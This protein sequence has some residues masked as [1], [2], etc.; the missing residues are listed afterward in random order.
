MARWSLRNPHYLNVLD[1]EGKGCEW[2]HEET[3][4]ETGRRNRKIYTV[5]Q[6][7]DPNNPQDQNYREL[8]RIIVCHQGKG[9][10]RDITFLG[11][12]TP[13]M[14]PFDEEAEKISESLRPKWEHPIE[15]LPANGGMNEQEAAFMKH[16]ME[17]FAKSAAPQNASVPK[18]EFEELKA[19]VA[20]LMEQN[21]ALQA[22]QEA[23]TPTA[24]RA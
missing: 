14:E 21:K 16:L 24:R 20:A 23:K 22:A 8:G 11:E 12:P 7:L 17:S 10:P 5:P 3:D 4:R 2:M 6:M 13:D 1:A 15:T 19:Q 9:E 18:E